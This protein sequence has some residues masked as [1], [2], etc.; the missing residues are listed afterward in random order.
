MLNP[1]YGLLPEKYTFPLLFYA[2]ERRNAGITAAQFMNDCAELRGAYTKYAEYS[3]GIVRDN[4]S[5]QTDYSEESVAN[6]IKTATLNATSYGFDELTWKWWLRD[7][8]ARKRRNYI[9]GAVGGLTTDYDQIM[10]G[11]RPAIWITK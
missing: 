7:P 2:M 8:A 4:G 9:I 6:L 11:T 1:D 5:G 3:Y 10:A